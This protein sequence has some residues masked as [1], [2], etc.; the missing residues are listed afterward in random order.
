MAL[1]AVY[2]HLGRQVRARV[3]HSR[4]HVAHYYHQLYATYYVL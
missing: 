2:L 3:P 4:E 1:R